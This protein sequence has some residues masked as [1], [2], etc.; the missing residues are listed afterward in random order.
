MHEIEMEDI[1]T[2]G[3]TAIGNRIVSMDKGYQPDAQ[4]PCGLESRAMYTL[5]RLMKIF[6]SECKYCP[7]TQ[8]T[9]YIGT[10]ESATPLHFSDTVQ[11]ALLNEGVRALVRWELQNKQQSGFR[12]LVQGKYNFTLLEFMSIFGPNMTD[13]GRRLFDKNRVYYMPMVEVVGKAAGT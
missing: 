9:V 12:R 6:G 2:V 8:D 5:W 13:F 11:V 7:F 10:H 3:L 4:F 1:V